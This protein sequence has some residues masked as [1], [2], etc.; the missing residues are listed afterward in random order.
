[1]SDVEDSNG[2]SISPSRSRSSSS[3]DDESCS[4][5]RSLSRLPSR[6]GRKYKIHSKHSYSR[7]RSYSGDRRRTYRSHSRGSGSRRSKYENPKT[8]R[9]LGIFGLSAFTTET[10][11][12]NIFVKYGDIDKMIIIMDAKSGK[13]RGFGFAYF[14]NHEDAKVAKEECSGMEIDGRRIRVD[15]SITK[16][17]HT[18]TP[19]IYMGRPTERYDRYDRV[20]DYD[21]YY[22]GAYRGGRGEG[23]G[24]E[25]RS[26]YDRSHSL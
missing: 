3:S 7:S 23:G 14:K 9:C 12:Y 20:R 5:S 8:K 24:E 6:K 17:P 18:P 22:E 1:M 10:R 13:S 21:D 15:F 19:G 11:L 2:S 25:R 16:R 26:R 4:R